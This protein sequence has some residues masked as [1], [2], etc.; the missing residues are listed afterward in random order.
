MNAHGATAPPPPFLFAL[1]DAAASLTV[2]PA[3]TSR[4][5][6]TWHHRFTEEHR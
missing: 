1:P 3:W 4:P 2:P 6:A 5:S